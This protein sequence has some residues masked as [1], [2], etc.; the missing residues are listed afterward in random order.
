MFAS[1]DA[2]LLLRSRRYSTGRDYPERGTYTCSLVR[3]VDECHT[4]GIIFTEGYG[5]RDLGSASLDLRRCSVINDVTLGTRIVVQLDIEVVNTCL[6]IIIR[7]LA[8]LV[9]LSRYDPRSHIAR[10]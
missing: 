2:K 10:C 4:A 5:L 7:Q 1:H 6:D 8:E 9:Y 3:T